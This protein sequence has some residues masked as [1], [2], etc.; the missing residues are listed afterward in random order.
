MR[1]DRGVPARDKGGLCGG[2]VLVKVPC[3]QG[4]PSMLPAEDLFG[5][6]YVLIHDLILAGAVQIPCRPGPAPA[7]TG[8]ESPSPKE[9]VTTSGAQSQPPSQRTQSAPPGRL[10]RPGGRGTLRARQDAGSSSG[11]TPPGAVARRRW[12]DH[13]LGLGGAGLAGQVGGLAI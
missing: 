2:Q 7:C 12:A 6:V 8:A 11:V 3:P 5:Y 9:P 1:V 10:R 4:R 13:A